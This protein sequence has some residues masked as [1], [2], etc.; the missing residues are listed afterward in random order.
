MLEKIKDIIINESFLNYAEWV[1]LNLL[2]GTIERMRDDNYKKELIDLND[3]YPLKGIKWLGDSTYKPPTKKSPLTL[4]R[5][6][7]PPEK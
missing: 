4:M 1:D 2:Q 5:S 6:T 7:Y 3:K